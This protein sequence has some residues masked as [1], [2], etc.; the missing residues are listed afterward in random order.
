MVSQRYEIEKFDGKIDFKKW[1]AKVQEAL[2]VQGLAKA[3]GGK[4]ESMKEEE[5]R[6]LDEE[7][8]STIRLYLSKEIH[9]SMAERSAKEIWE[10]LEKLYSLERALINR[11]NLKKQFYRLTMD[12]STTIQDHIN[13]FSSILGELSNLDVNISEE[14]KVLVF[15]AS[16]PKKYDHWVTILLY[17]KKTVVL[18]EIT[19]VL[20]FNENYWC[21]TNANNHAGA[22][23]LIIPNY[24]ECDQCS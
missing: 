12:E 5:W 21:E 3:L 14:D 7:A 9:H 8:C 19:S 23:Y 16:L 11:F 1:Q 24:F 13:E 4:P 17:G 20:L 6:K 15:L 10:E 2:V 18:D 22:D